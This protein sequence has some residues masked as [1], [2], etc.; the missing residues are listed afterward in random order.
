LPT[1]RAALRIADQRRDRIPDRCVKRGEPTDGAV[2]AWAIELGHADLLWRAF[3]PLLRAV[4]PV[5]RRGNERIVLPLSSPAWSSLRAGLRWAVV[6][7]G[8]GTG[9]L[10]LGLIQGDVG[11]VVVGAVLLVAAWVVR[12][13]VLWRRWVGVVLRPGGEAV[14]VTRVHP[15]FGEAAR[16]LFVRSVGGR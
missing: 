1:T 2:R 14:A 3:G 16:A 11:V 15:A 9:S 8:L 5:L 7:A 13:L 6:L 10:V 12:G 4:A